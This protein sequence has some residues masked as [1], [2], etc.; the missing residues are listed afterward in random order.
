VSPLKGLL[1][2]HSE[3]GSGGGIEYQTRTISFLQQNPKKSDHFPAFFRY[4]TVAL[5]LGH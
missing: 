2:V 3:G 5:E 4:A 1:L